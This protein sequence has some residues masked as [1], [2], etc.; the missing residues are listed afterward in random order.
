MA[1]AGAALLGMA[2]RARRELDLQT[3]LGPAL[4]AAK[5]FAA[6]EVEQTYARARTLCQ[7]VGDTPQLF[8]ALWGLTRFYQVSVQLQTSRASSRVS[9]SIS[10]QRSPSPIR[11]WNSRT[12]PARSSCR[13]GRG[14]ARTGRMNQR[15]CRAGNGENSER[16]ERSWLSR[17]C[18]E[19]LVGRACIR[20]PTV[21]CARA[22]P[23]PPWLQACGGKRRFRAAPVRSPV[24]LEFSQAG[25]GRRRRVAAEPRAQ[26]SQHCRG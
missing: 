8:Q 22:A 18:G 24:L 21:D 14:K 13:P 6:L 25:D 2:R 9:R 26:R 5:G 1:G 11:I 16:P 19:S 12:L 15:V 7:Q 10:S 17:S 4:M 23:L 20:T 3:A